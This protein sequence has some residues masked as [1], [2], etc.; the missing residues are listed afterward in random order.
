MPVLGAPVFEA[1]SERLVGAGMELQLLCA[2]GQFLLKFSGLKLCMLA[3]P[4]STCKALAEKLCRVH[5]DHKRR[6]EKSKRHYQP[7]AQGSTLNTFHKADK[8]QSGT[9]TNFGD[10][11]VIGRA[12]FA[13]MVTCQVDRTNPSLAYLTDIGKVLRN[14][15]IHPMSRLLLQDCTWKRPL[16][17]SNFVIIPVLPFKPL[18][19]AD[20]KPNTST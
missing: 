9:C 11:T 6:M 17:W 16:A 1:W 3:C 10:M 12:S 19:A 4:I 14:R 13:R 8:Q 15:Q 20:C 2:H 7:I 5:D 18:P